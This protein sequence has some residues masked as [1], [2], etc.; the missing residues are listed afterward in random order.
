MDDL[1][2][3]DRGLSGNEI[4]QLFLG[5]VNNSGVIEYRAIKKPEV[6]T[7]SA[8]DARPQSVI[9]R[10]EV[11]SIG[12]DVSESTSSVDRSF[13]KGTIS[14][15]QAWYTAENIAVANGGSVT[16][17]KDKSDYGRNF[18]NVEGNPRLLAFGLNG[19]PVVSFD[20]DDLLWT[21]HNFDPLTNTGYTMV[22]LAR[23]TGSKTSGSSVLEPEIS[24]LVFTARKWVSGMRRDGFRPPDRLTVTGT[25][26]SA[27]L[28][29][30]RETLQPVCGRMVF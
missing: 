7:L 2:V 11:T 29:T 28:R 30:I 21:G 13:Q 23:Y 15:L 9:L 4:N 20:G 10:A 19:K 26:I 16:N 14:G 6:R 8:L 1:R 17:W 22:S 12:G 24:F 27:Q 3:Y 5:D 25:C 18:E